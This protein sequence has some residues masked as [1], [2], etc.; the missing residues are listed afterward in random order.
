[1][2]DD[3]EM[4]TYIKDV[5]VFGKFNTVR[6]LLNDS[7]FDPTV[8]HN[9]IFAF[10]AGTKWAPSGILRMTHI[11][12]LLLDDPRINPAIDNNKILSFAT[13]SGNRHSIEMLLKDPRVDPTA[14]NNHAFNEACGQEHSRIVK[15]FLEDGRVDPSA[16][17]S[18]SLRLAARY[19]RLKIVKLLLK[20]P[21]VDPSVFCSGS[22]TA[23]V[24]YGHVKVAKL[25]LKDP[26]VNPGVD[27][28]K[29]LL[30][31]VHPKFLS[32]FKLVVDDPR[33]DP[34]TRGN[35]ALHVA[36]AV[37]P[38]NE[39][40]VFRLLEDRRVHDVGF[41][42]M[43]SEE[44]ARIHSILNYRT[45]RKAAL[46]WG[47]KE[48]GQGWMDIGVGF[49]PYLSDFVLRPSDQ[50]K[51]SGNKESNDPKKENDNVETV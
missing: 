13:R 35:M 42:Y 37:R 44:K 6:R 16:F 24:K 22:F 36:V 12:R 43:G 19:G 30:D 17:T 4:R 38:I 33:V 11:L 31:M 26:R 9:L 10:A 40:L 5:M 46:L 34:S 48:I 29:V 47:C 25:L 32:L 27:E 7:D 41:E 21:R 2:D 8:S 45:E 51:D 1:M 3:D 20:D 50:S 15:M 14:A 39:E 18:R 23:A 49:E 28:S